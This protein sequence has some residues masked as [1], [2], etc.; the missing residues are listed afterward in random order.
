MSPQ[1]RKRKKPTIG[2]TGGIGSGKSVVSQILASQGCAIIDSD[3]LIHEELGTQDVRNLLCRWWG[4]RICHDDGTLNR[5]AIAAI[6]FDDPAELARLQDT[7][8]PRIEM[9]R[10]V[11]T[12][13]FKSDPKV[14]AIVLDTP[15]LFEVG[16][17]EVCDAVIFVDTDRLSRVNRVLSTRGWTEKEFDRREKLLNPL[18]KNREKADYIVENHFGLDDLRS[19]VESVFSTVL[20]S[21]SDS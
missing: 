15:K 6:V 4:D 10:R 17:N 13:Q 11:L 18:D 8:Y 16:L 19:K 1:D 14:K 5:S 7:L 3:H 21:F 20:T 9:R 12:E 2:V